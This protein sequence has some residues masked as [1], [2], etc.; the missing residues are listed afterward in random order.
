MALSDGRFTRLEDRGSSG[1]CPAL[2]F[3]DRT[4]GF[5][6]KIIKRINGE[7]SSVGLV[8]LPLR[9][10]AVELDLEVQL[11]TPRQIE[12]ISTVVER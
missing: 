8:Q 5:Q 10:N 7:S 4:G 9:E 6:H 1:A 2:C 11:F 12:G 3:F